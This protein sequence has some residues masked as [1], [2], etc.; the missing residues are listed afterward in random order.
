MLGTDFLMQFFRVI[1]TLACNPS[2][3]LL[4]ANPVNSL[5]PQGE[6]WLVLVRVFGIL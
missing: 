6:I 1:H 3:L 4:E 2:S 5:V